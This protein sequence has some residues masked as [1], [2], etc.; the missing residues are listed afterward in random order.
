VTDE[1]IAQTSAEREAEFLARLTR[2]ETALDRL[3]RLEHRLRLDLQ[4]F[5]YLVARRGR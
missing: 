2:L 4:R 1:Q 5:E 3:E